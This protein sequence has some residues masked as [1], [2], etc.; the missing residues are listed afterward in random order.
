MLA[1]LLKQSCAPKQ[2]ARTYQIEAENAKS[3]GA[4][5]WESAVQLDEQGV[6]E[7]RDRGVHKDVEQDLQ[8]PADAEANP[9]NPKGAFQVEDH[10]CHCPCVVWVCALHMEIQYVS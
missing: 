4:K 8:K 9:H 3:H 5:E 2:V 1:D 10:H 7:R 6:E